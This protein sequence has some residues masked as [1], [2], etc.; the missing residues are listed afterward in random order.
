MRGC[1]RLP[2]TARRWL[3]RAVCVFRVTFALR[4]AIL[5]ARGPAVRLPWVRTGIGCEGAACTN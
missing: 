4:R 3:R 5:G 2:R 1:A